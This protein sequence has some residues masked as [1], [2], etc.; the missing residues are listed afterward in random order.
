MACTGTPDRHPPLPSWGG[1][2]GEPEAARVPEG[3]AN[4]L[5]PAVGNDQPFY[6]LAIA[7]QVLLDPAHVAEH[8]PDGR[9]T[10]PRA[11]LEAQVSGEWPLAFTLRHSLPLPPGEGWGEGQDEALHHLPPPEGVGRHSS[12]SASHS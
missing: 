9:I 12:S 1:F 7:R 8:L 2:V 5:I 11:R 6:R 10:G 3:V 4:L